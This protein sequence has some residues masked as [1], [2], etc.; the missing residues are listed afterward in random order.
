MR[1][2]L[3]CSAIAPRRPS[4][5]PITMLIPEGRRHEEEQ[6]LAR[7]RDGQAVEPYETVRR[8]K[9]GS[10]LDISLAVSPIVDEDGR[11][12]GASKIARDITARKRAAGRRAAQP[13]GAERSRRPRAV[14]NL[15][16]RLAAQDRADERALRRRALSTTCGPSS[17]A[18]S[19]RSCA[20]SGRNRS[21]PRSS[22]RSARRSRPARRTGRVISRARAPT[23]TTSSRTNGS[24]IASRCRTATGCG[25][26]LF[27][28]DSPA[29]SGARPARGRPAQGRVPGDARARAAQP[30]GADPQRP[31]DP[32]PDRR[33]RAS[34]RRRFTR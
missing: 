22:P 1:V 19:G 8:R 28:L 31:A 15:Y 7:I 32:A 16:R 23:R 26:L 10:L 27:R 33:G 34:G 12:V 20:C 18:T 21:R 5:G 11:I 29:Q 30:A 25:L 9:D 17:A 14:R 24:C 13:R 6:I 4:A 3:A 2:Q